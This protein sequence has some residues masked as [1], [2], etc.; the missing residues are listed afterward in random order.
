MRIRPFLMFFVLSLAL[1]AYSLQLA[2]A[3][4]LL[5][6]DFEKAGNLIGGRSNT[7]E[8]E[9]SRALAIRTEKEFFGDSGKSLM[10]RY[11]KKLEGGP[12]GHGGWCGYYTL[13]RNSDRYLDATG[14]KSVTFQVKGAKGSENFKIG[15]A[16]KHWEGLGDSVKSEAI[17]KYLPEGKLTDKW[18]KA[19][20]P[21]EAFSLEL[22]ELASF[23]ICFETDCFPEGG[24]GGVAVGL[25]KGAIYVD[26]LTLE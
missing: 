23:A 8:K 5:V 10:L 22:S 21:L 2:H 17:G 11:D 19:E 14:F 4:T 12:Y 26:D 3:E 6:D 18:Q 24:D 15:L 20:I 16:D 1:I 9:P 13:L 25:P 7:Y